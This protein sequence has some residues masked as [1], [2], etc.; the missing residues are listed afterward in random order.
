MSLV[1]PVLN[2]WLRWTEKPFLERIADPVKARESFEAK[3]RIYFRPP[4]GVAMHHTRI[5]GI[6][7][8]ELHPKKRAGH[9]T[10]FYCHGGAYVMGSPRTHSAMVARLCH[11]ASVRAVLPEYRKAPE[12]PFPTALDDVEAAYLA[13]IK[14]VPARSVI[15]GGDSAGGGLTF[16]LLGS[17]IRKGL[18]VP[19]GVFAFSPLTDLTFSGASAEANRQRDALLPVSRAADMSAMYLDKADPRDPRASPLFADYSGVPPCW[20]TVGDTEIL[21]DDTLRLVDK[22]KDAGGRVVLRL[23]RDVPHVWP[24][25]HNYLPEARATLRHLATWIKRQ[26]LGSD[27]N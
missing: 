8:L 25:F 20:I 2:T 1:R 10:V 7:A 19:G 14:E 17:L 22:L 26:E 24:I 18:S 11:L 16:A 23:E 27:G 13:L 5:G 6:P 15:L 3:A 12:H 21:R 4:R 9:L